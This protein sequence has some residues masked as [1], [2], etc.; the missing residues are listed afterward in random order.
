MISKKAILLINVIVL[1][2][3]AGAASDG[4]LYSL[5]PAAGTVHK[6]LLAKEHERLTREN[7]RLRFIHE[8]SIEFDINPHIVSLVYEYAR[9]YVDPSQLEWRLVQ[10]PEFLTHILL[11]VIHAESNGEPKALGDDG[12]AAGLTQIWT[13]TAQ[14]YGEVSR[15]ELLDPET[16]IDYSFRHFHYLLKRYRGNLALALYSWNRGQGTVDR[17]IR[18]GE[19]PNNGYGPKVYSAALD[20]GGESVSD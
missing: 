10:T 3:L 11:S 20:A 12:R 19:P 8:L 15:A 17:L 2:L 7:K 6:E 13:T 5:D 9:R 18:Y 1:L 14:Q 4:S 16:N